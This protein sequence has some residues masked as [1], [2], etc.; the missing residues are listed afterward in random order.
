MCFSVQG[1]WHNYVPVGEDITMNL[2]R[3]LRGSTLVEL[4]PSLDLENAAGRSNRLLSI[5]ENQ[6]S[7]IFAKLLT[8]SPHEVIDIIMRERVELNSQLSEDL[9]Y[10]EFVLEAL[11]LLQKRE[12]SLAAKD[13]SDNIKSD[14]IST[15]K[16]TEIDDNACDS[17][18]IFVFEDNVSK[19]SISESDNVS[20][21]SMSE[22]DNNENLDSATSN[23]SANAVDNFAEKPNPT[24][25]Y[26]YFYQ[27][28]S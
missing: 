1:V 11:H 17:S 23:P 25:K 7:S 19:R 12:D 5:S 13:M 2:M 16:S 22:S 20:K 24:E 18:D 21:T 3:R 8:A 15:P 10:P 6:P 27:G 9:E 4:A 28:W 14:L 26:F